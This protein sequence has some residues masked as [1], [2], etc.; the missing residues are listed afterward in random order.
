MRRVLDAGEFIAP[1]GIRALSK[2]H[3]VRRELGEIPGLGEAMIDYEPGESRSGLFGGNSNWRGPVWMPLNYL[4]VR[5][6]D[7][8][9]RYLTESFTVPAPAL[10]EKEV[11]LA[12]AADL[13]A[14]RLIGIFRRNGRGLRH[15]FPAESPFQSDPHWRD[16][17]LFHEYFHGETGE[18]LGAS[19]QTGWT[20]LVAN[21]LVRQYERRGRGAPPP[22][23][24]PLP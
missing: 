4:F 9:H 22:P 11:T 2:L 23:V 20:A 21:L 18:G 17:H 15:A 12:E 13:I 24:E 1:H 10:G 14:E 7:K 3:A 5:A 8:T 19:H 6:L 16:L